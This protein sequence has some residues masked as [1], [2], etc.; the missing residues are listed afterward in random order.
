MKTIRDGVIESQRPLRLMLPKYSCAS[1]VYGKQKIPG[2]QPTSNNLESLKGKSR[3]IIQ[4]FVVIFLLW[5]PSNSDAQLS[6]GTTCLV[7]SLFGIL[8]YRILPGGFITLFSFSSDEG[9][10]T[11]QGSSSHPTLASSALSWGSSSAPGNLPSRVW[12]HLLEPLKLCL[13]LPFGDLEGAVLL[14]EL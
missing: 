5:S 13:L 14:L 1:E 2:L 11:F 3:E 9:L 7:Q 8:L 10:T 12:L 6:L 4:F